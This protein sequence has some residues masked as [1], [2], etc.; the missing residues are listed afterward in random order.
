[1][2]YSGNIKNRELKLQEIPTLSARAVAFNLDSEVVAKAM[3]Q[4][5]SPEVGEK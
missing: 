1:M 4:D 2:F 3:N 5:A